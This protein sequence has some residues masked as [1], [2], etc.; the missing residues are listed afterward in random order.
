MPESFQV[1]QALFGYR[2]GHNL[3][4]ASVA[5]APRVRQFLANVTDVSGPDSSVGFEASY[6]G[7]PVPET[8]YYALF[9]TWPAPEMPRPGCVWSH[10]LL[11]GLTDLARIPDLS[12]LRSLCLRP[13]VPPNL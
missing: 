2:E 8:N 6:T 1:E 5:L 7:L 12:I 3:V 13:T 9:C 4:A 11:L 10:V